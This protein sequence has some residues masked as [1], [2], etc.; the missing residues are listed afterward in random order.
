MFDPT[1]PH[2]SSHLISLNIY[3][4]A[5]KH[6]YNDHPWDQEKVVVVQRWPLFRGSNYEIEIINY[7]L[8]LK[9]TKNDKAITN[10]SLVIRNLK[11]LID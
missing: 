6:V 11:P 9:N 8:N 4:S 7:K 2:S 10:A 5:V 3:Y 1:P